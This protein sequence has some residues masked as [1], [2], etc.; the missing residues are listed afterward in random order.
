MRLALVLTLAAALPSF[1]G[2][3]DPLEKGTIRF[4]P[5]GD[6]QNIPARYRLDALR[7]DFETLAIGGPSGRYISLGNRMAK[8]FPHLPT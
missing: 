2:A 7:F 1:S 6:Q 5:L 8:F 4:E 3:A